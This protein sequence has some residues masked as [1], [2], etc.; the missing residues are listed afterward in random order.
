MI[1]TL[2]I[3][4]FVIVF[5]AFFIGKNLS[6]LCT[7][8]FFKTYTD[9]PVAILV[10]IAF[11]AG[12]VFSLILI[13]LSKVLKNKVKNEEKLDDKKSDTKKKSLLKRTLAKSSELNKNKDNSDKLSNE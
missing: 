5:L 7:F 1:A 12:I 10:F 4:L 8:W 9:L 6:N 3:F 11:A 2:V 13:S